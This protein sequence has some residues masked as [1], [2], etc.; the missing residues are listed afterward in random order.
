MGESGTKTVFLWNISGDSDVGG[1]EHT[2]ETLI[3][4]PCFVTSQSRHYVSFCHL[5]DMTCSVNFSSSSVEGFINPHFTGKLLGELN[6][7]MTRMVQP[8]FI[9][10]SVESM[11]ITQIILMITT[12]P[13]LTLCLEQCWG[14]VNTAQELTVRVQLLGSKS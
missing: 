13:V 10:W 11:S 4:S 8:L 12:S 7:S 1:E 9:V 14:S 3:L 2:K 6:A 5:L